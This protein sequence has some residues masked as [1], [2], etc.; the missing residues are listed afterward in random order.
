[1]VV[2][3]VV[4]TDRTRTGALG[5]TGRSKGEEVPQAKARTTLTAIGGP[6]PAIAG[7]TGPVIPSLSHIL[8]TVKTLGASVGSIKGDMNIVTI[9]VTSMRGLC[10]REEED[11]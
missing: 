7:S 8:S 4:D 10:V 6:A 1:M 5:S 2:V 9:V 11:E 3:V